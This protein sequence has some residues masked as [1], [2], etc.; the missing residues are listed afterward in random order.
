VDF[1][2]VGIKTVWSAWNDR[3]RTHMSIRDENVRTTLV[4]SAVRSRLSGAS[5]GS[6]T[7]TSLSRS[8]RNFCRA[9]SW[10]AEEGVRRY[11]KVGVDARGSPPRLI[12]AP[13]LR[14]LTNTHS[15]FFR[16]H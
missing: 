14:L 12:L 8:L 3:D 7:E 15:R 6:C 11:T 16:S 10:P 13:P 9:E 4:E 2:V 1:A 5:P